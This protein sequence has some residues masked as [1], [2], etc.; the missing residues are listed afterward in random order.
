M[1]Q[2]TIE[3]ISP[4][5]M[6]ELKSIHE[7]ISDYQSKIAELTERADGLVPKHDLED[8]REFGCVHT[9]HKQSFC[10][11]YTYCIRSRWAHGA[12]RDCFEKKKPVFKP[13]VEY[14]TLGWKSVACVGGKWCGV[15]HT[16][17]VVK[18]TDRTLILEDKTQLLKS[19]IFTLEDCTFIKDRSEH[20]YMCA[21]NPE[22]LDMQK[23]LLEVAHREWVEATSLSRV[24]L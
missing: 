18:E 13:R 15:W 9:C 21:D 1:E 5:V 19:T 6:A 3:T 14:P 11:C 10:D 8:C 7:Q 20:T 22:T 12:Y 16:D 23:T 24:K 2:K 17:K 4:E